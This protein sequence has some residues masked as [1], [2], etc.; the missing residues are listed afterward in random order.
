MTYTGDQG[1][2]RLNLV[3]ICTFFLVFSPLL[4]SQ[5]KHSGK[6][7]LCFGP[8]RRI[9]LFNPSYPSQVSCIA[10]LDK[11]PRLLIVEPLSATYYPST[12]TEV[13]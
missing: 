8:P 3:I 1:Q 7:P 4:D 12:H 5:S 11:T 2:S 10:L 13:Q 9:L 6:S